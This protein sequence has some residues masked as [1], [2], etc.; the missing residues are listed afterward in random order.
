V[1][2]RSIFGCQKR[3]RWPKWTPASNI[4]FMDVF[5]IS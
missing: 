3:L 2:L 5:A 1:V 4:F